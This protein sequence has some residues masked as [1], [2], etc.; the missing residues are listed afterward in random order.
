MKT[1]VKKIEGNWDLGF[2]LDKHTL[3]SVCIGQNAQGYP[4]FDTVRPEAGEALYQLKY[5][6]DWKQISPLAKALE[7]DIYPKF[8]DVGLI[9]PIPASKKRARQPV[10]ELAK[11]LGKLVKLNVFDNILSKTPAA[12]EL[13]N[14][15]SK[16][17]KEALLKESF[18]F[19]DG[20]Q[21]EGPWNALIVDDLFDTGAT[22][23]A[24]CAALRNYKKI[25]K[26]Y[27][28]TITWK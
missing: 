9:I 3:S 5:K 12:K 18:S 19:S 28:A 22:L 13:K 6:E 15:T 10:Y 27:V 17:E 11:E 20:I 2:A 7:K 25:S 23:E 1:S 8:K 14:A 16:A 21:G 24:A 4:I 26:I